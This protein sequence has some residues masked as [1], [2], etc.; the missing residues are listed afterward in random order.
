MR[1]LLIGLEDHLADRLEGDALALA[2]LVVQL[3]A[4]DVYVL[5]N[6]PAEQILDARGKGF[7]VAKQNGT[8]DIID[9]VV[10][11][12]SMPRYRREVDG[13]A[14]KHG[15]RIGRVGHGGDGNV[16]VSV[17]QKDE[18]VRKAFLREVFAASIGDRRCGVGRARHRHREGRRVPGAGRSD[19]GHAQGRPAS[20]C[21]LRHLTRWCRRAYPE[22]RS[23]LPSRG[24][25]TC[26][27]A[28]PD[29]RGRSGA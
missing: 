9:V 19:E 11:R 8:D 23:L 24:T 4:S 18:A 5:P 7:W 14:A 10:P 17:L 20:R 26:H 22:A 13:L 27:A 15:T 16:H 6:G 29:L 1:Y 25:G 2:E 3:G 12:A 28:Y 21:A